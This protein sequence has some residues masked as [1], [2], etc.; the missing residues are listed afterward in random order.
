MLASAGLPLGT[1]PEMAL[2][3]GSTSLALICFALGGAALA[4]G[5]ARQRLGWRPSGLP[6]SVLL[7]LLLGLLAVSQL[8]EWAIALAGYRD[9]G[10]LAEFRRAVAGV[11]GA[12][13]ALSL[14]GLALLPGFGEELAFRGWIQGG[15][16]TRMG[17][18]AAVGLSAVLFGLL[19]GDPLH[20]SGA[21]VLGLYLGAVT[22]LAGSIRPAVAC[23][24]VNNLL[25]TLTV[26]SGF[27]ALS[28]WLVVAGVF[29]GPWAFRRLWLQ[30]RVAHRALKRSPETDLPRNGGTAERGSLD[31]PV[32]R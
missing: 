3:A 5:S 16:A 30:H 21:F 22:A 27:Q 2:A 1:A 11:G 7:G 15:L 26:A 20:A 24:I 4:G 14:V 25:A 29:A 32:G 19:H 17:A 9:V 18:P 31:P 28:G 6:A 8:A 10:T 12:E 13:L 23:H